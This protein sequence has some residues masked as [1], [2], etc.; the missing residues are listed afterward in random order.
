MRAIDVMT[1]EVIS[2]DE[3]GSVAAVAKLL[4]GRGI[5]GVPVVDSANRVIG[6]V[7]EGDLRRD[8]N[9]APSVVVARN[10]DIHQPAR[11]RIRQGS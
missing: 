9:R 2:V 11:R 8:R 5:S 3:N 10:D 7:S 4:A 6:M 1:C